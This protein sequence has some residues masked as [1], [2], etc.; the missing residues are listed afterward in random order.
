M[1]ILTSSP[2]LGRLSG[3]VGKSEEGID[4]A[5]PSK[6]S[7]VPPQP[8]SFYPQ[9]NQRDRNILRQPKALVHMRHCDRVMEQHVDLAYRYSSASNLHCLEAGVPFNLGQ[10]DGCRSSGRS[11][12]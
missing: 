12:I 4:G 7:L 5:V 9:S 3:W 11:E 8:L 1:N 2:G 6:L 10:N